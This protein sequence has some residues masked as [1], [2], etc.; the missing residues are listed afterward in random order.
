MV[1]AENDC[2]VISGLATGGREAEWDTDGTASLKALVVRDG[3]LVGYVSRIEGSEELTSPA[4][5]T[6]LSA[7]TTS[8][9]SR[10]SAPSRRHL[11]RRF[12][13]KAASSGVSSTASVTGYRGPV[14]ES[15][16]DIAAMRRAS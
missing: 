7:P 12:L 16:R 1:A 9:L 5:L 13:V 8:A 15:C 3:M 11:L 6:Q 10:T 14:N 2:G 4:S